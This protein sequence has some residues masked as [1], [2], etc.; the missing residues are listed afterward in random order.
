MFPVLAK[1]RALK[2]LAVIGI[3]LFVAICAFF[4]GGLASPRDLKA[5]SFVGSWTDG[6]VYLRVDPEGGRLGEPYSLDFDWTYSEG[7]FF[8][9]SPDMAFRL[10]SFDKYLEPD[11]S[12]SL[13]YRS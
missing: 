9:A 8:C 10:R 5:E 1:H 13:F 7:T 11:F 6:K 4:A 3:A 2:V 12:L